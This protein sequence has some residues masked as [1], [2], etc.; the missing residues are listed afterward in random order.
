M[1]EHDRCHAQEFV[2]TTFDDRIPDCMEQRG[3]QHG[4]IN[5]QFQV[6]RPTDGKDRLG[7]RAMRR[8]AIRSQMNAIELKQADRNRSILMPPTISAMHQYTSRSRIRLSAALLLL[9]LFSAP[10]QAWFWTAPT[11]SGINADLATDYPQVPVITVEQL[12]RRMNGTTT[13][14]LLLVDTRSS[15]EFEV[16]HLPGAVHA[17]T[18]DAVRKLLAGLAQPL[19]VVLYCSVGVRSARVADKLL[20]AGVQD[21]S[22]LQGSIFEWANRGLPLRRGDQTVQIVHPF[23]S[24]W[25]S[26]LDRQRWSH[27]P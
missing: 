23:N 21:V 12:H 13:R 27:E 5:C 4:Q 2:R 1:A 26:L 9:A 10:A 3:S 19:P 20:A 14:A 6:T 17:E 8:K 15:E 25:G 24:R 18:A 11:W 16:S 22:N 7:I